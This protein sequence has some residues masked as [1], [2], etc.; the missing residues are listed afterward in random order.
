MALAWAAA[1]WAAGLALGPTAGLPVLSWLILT[2]AAGALA[3]VFR[4]TQ[5]YPWIFGLLAVGFLGALR[6]QAALPRPT[7]SSLQSYN[8]I[9]V[10]LTIRGVLLGLPVVRGRT[11]RVLLRAEEVARGEG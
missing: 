1:G 11:V 10:P 7:A 4:K 2:G 3:F 6:T 8:D 5:V 9:P